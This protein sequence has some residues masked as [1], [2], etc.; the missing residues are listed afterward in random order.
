VLKAASISRTAFMSRAPAFG[1]FATSITFIAICGRVEI[2]WI[3]LHK[4]GNVGSV[5]VIKTCLSE[6]TCR[7][8]SQAI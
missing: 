4:S 6:L 5:S 8:T 2:P 1:S 7:L 3:R